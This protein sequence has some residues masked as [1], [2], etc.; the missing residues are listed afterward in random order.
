LKLAGLKRS[1][2]YAILQRRKQ[3]DRNQELKEWIS[4]IFHEHKGRYGY[5]R[6]QMELQSRFDRTV[7]HKKV[8]RLM[9]ELQLSC[10]IRRK[11]YRSYKGPVGTKA[12]HLIQ[13]K[14]RAKRPNA[15]W[16]TDITEFI[17][18]QKKFYLSPV[19]DMYNGEIV[20][21]AIGN[22]P[23]KALVDTML[24]RAFARHSKKKKL[25]LHSDQGWQYQT[26]HYRRRLAK[27]KIT[28]SMSRKGNC[29]DNAIIESFFGTFKSEF[30]RTEKWKSIPHFL[31]ELKRYIHYYNHDRIKSRLKVS[32]VQYRLHHDPAIV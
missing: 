10:Q 22:S 9:Q 1:T 17:L 7:N 30:L 3:G 27:Q 18:F 26:P 12:P 5:R 21:Y 24:D 29:L 31:R 28:Q 25:I 20:A 6:I 19:L 15:K 4:A 8:L 23:D 14:F 2:F 16:T 11:K 32:P 13:R